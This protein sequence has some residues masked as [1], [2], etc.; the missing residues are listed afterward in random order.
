MSTKLKV[1]VVLSFMLI[2]VVGVFAGHS[3][4]NLEHHRTHYCTT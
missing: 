2:G 4:R 3:I 1:A